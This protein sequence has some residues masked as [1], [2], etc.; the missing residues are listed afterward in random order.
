M[1]RAGLV[2]RISS[3]HQTTFQHWRNNM[4]LHEHYRPQAWSEVVGQD[5]ALRQLETLRRRGLGGRAYWIAGKSGTGKTTI[6]RLL[7]TELADPVNIEEIDCAECSVHLVQ[8]IRREAGF[9]AI[10]AKPGRVWIIN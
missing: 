6:A 4:Q 5:K 10:G 8:R 2:R 7:A 3:F 1:R 9:R